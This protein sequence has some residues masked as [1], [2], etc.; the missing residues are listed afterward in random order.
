M[1]SFTPDS[2]FCWLTLTVAVVHSVGTSARIL[3]KNSRTSYTTAFQDPATDIPADLP[4][5]H[6]TECPKI[7]DTAF[8]T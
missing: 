4:G 6:H 8:Q 1:L 7:V 5:L 3:V 2:T